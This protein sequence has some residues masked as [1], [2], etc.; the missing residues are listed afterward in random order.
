[1]YFAHTKI[2][3]MKKWVLSIL[4]LANYSFVEAQL[5]L[6]IEKLWSL[7][8][9][10][11][12]GASKDGATIYYSV[13]IPDIN[14]NKNKTKFYSIPLQGG[15]AMEIP[16]VPNQ[17][18]VTIDKG[19]YNVKVS[20][21]GKK[22]IFTREVKMQKMH[23]TDIYPSLSK[24]N[25][26]VYNDL[27]QRHWDTWEEGAYEHVFVADNVADHALREKDIMANEL[28]DCPQKPHGGDDDLIFTPDSKSILYVTK[29]KSGKAYA[30]STNTDFY[31]YQ[32]ETGAVSNITER[33]DGL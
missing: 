26:Y 4:L 24:S 12:Q 16:E 13:S 5:N 33:Y 1:M 31:L 19:G 20:P 2:F 18:N 10:S 3:I 8:R 23:S 29:K 28:F 9:V 15:K 11:Y 22:V 6:T 25:V 21:D 27:N 32:I 30:L 7:G 17:T 14:E